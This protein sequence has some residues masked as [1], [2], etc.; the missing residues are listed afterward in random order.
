VAKE[1]F[2]YHSLQFFNF[3]PELNSIYSGLSIAMGNASE[4]VQRQAAYV[5]TS[6]EEDGLAMLILPRRAEVVTPVRTGFP[7]SS[8]R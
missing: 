5:T 8:G 2:S 7:S 4:E 3:Q 1:G 6:C